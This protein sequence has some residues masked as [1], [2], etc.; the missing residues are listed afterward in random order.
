[1]E[2][3]LAGSLFLGWTWSIVFRD[4]QVLVIDNL[5]SLYGPDHGKLILM[6]DTR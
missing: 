2:D 5:S 1:M 3:G 4:L 6:S